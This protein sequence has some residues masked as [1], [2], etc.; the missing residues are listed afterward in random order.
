MAD[1]SITELI[2][3]TADE[4]NDLFRLGLYKKDE[5]FLSFAE[6]EGYTIIGYQ[7]TGNRTSTRTE[8]NLWYHNGSPFFRV[9]KVR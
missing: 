5:K 4:F 2:H 8:Y 1:S 9:I 7:L 6:K 3:Y